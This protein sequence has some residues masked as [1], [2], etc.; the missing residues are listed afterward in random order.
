MLRKLF[1]VVLVILTVVPFTAPFPTFDLTHGSHSDST[2][3]DD[4]SHALLTIAA[5]T[6]LRTRFVSHVRTSVS[7]HHFSVPGLRARRS[8]PAAPRIFDRPSLAILRI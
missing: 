5:A 3:V 1:A 6:R 7:T 8:E 4:G 2:S